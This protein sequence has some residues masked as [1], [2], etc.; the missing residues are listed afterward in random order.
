[1]S[2]QLISALVFS[3]S[4]TLS[5]GAQSVYP[6]QFEGKFAVTDVATPAV[7]SF[8]LKDVRLLPPDFVIASP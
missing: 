2:K 4:V 6:G 7:K 1:M 5:I 8:D 3:L